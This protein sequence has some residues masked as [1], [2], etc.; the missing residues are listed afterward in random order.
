LRFFIARRT[1]LCDFFEYLR[2]IH[3]S[4]WNESSATIPIVGQREG[5]SLPLA[6]AAAIPRRGTS[7]FYVN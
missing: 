7:G 6:Q 4:C 3:F 1:E 5:S 2:A